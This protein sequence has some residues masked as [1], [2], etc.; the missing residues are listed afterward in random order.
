MVDPADK[1]A[2]LSMSGMAQ[3]D[4]ALRV[5]KPG[6]TSA[7]VIGALEYEGRSVIVRHGDTIASALVAA[8][9]V[10]FRHDNVGSRRGI[11]CGMGVCT[12]CAVTV[13]GEQGRLACLEKARPGSSVAGDA[14][15][16]S[17]TRVTL[18]ARRKASAAGN[19]HRCELLVVGAGPAGLRAALAAK[20]AGVEVLIVDERPALG[21]QYFKQPAAARIADPGRLDAQYSG[22]RELLDA[23]QNAGV[24]VLSGVRLWGLHRTTSGVEAF[25]SPKHYAVAKTIIF[26]TG[27]YERGVPFPGWTL[28]G[29]MQTGAAQTLLRS[30]LVAPGR[31]VLVS[32]NGPLNLQVAA[33][34]C[35]AGVE[36]VAVAELA[37]VVSPSKFMALVRMGVASPKLVRE[38]AN[39]IAR[40]R[41]HRVP[42]LFGSSVVDVRGRDCVEMGVVARIG[43]TGRIITGSERS[44]AVD[45]VLTGFGFVPSG[46]LARGLGCVARRDAQTGAA[47]VVRDWRGRTSVERVWI[48]GDG[49]GI[50]GAQVAQAMGELAGIDVARVLG[51]H[52]SS[53]LADK[54][55]RARRW[56]RRSVAF[57]E[58]LWRLFAAPSLTLQLTSGE[59]VVCRCEG[60]R[61]STL[62]TALV[63]WTGSAG[64]VKRL[65]RAG[66]GKC[67]G[68][69]CGPLVVEL[70]AKCS[71][72][73][74]DDRSGFAPQYPVIPTQVQ[75]MASTP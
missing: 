51:R 9:I 5:D 19:S 75:V 23:V 2:K 16:R 63:P 14:S 4:T 3:G 60:V 57:Q 6:L 50:Q 21:G 20:R 72:T 70:A 62:E 27:A 67:Q 7:P 17:P 26:A 61:R 47:V 32:G 49:S 28:P 41:R 55:S 37:K 44:F 31:R 64:V 36:V 1:N 48:V 59:T 52:I 10:T 53:G 35:E 8:G 13:D 68:R 66:M 46:D 15:I 73:A 43:K 12:E 25:L 71:G 38:G 22:G 30:Y 34:L 45:A 74:Y 69:Y 58:G 29:V 42:L 65:T 39:Y 56:L 24:A 18:A 54:E 33:E 11:F 40:L